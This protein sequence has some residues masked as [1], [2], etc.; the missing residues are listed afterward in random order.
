M[1]K[2]IIYTDL[3]LK[4]QEQNFIYSKETYAIN[5]AAMEVHST[6]GPSFLESVYQEALEIELAK[7]NIPFVSQQKLQIQYK[8]IQ[9]HQYF[10][11]DLVCY[12]KIIVEL[13]AVSS[14]LPEHQAQ[15]INYLHATNLKMGILF[16]FG[17][18]SLYFKR[19]PNYLP[20][21]HNL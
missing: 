17:E 3:K 20:L 16:N 10:I 5:G 19:F 13:K 14:I 21:S 18:E 9:L 12:D 2:R 4:M 7:R 8:G 1:P 6:L 15:I 11:A